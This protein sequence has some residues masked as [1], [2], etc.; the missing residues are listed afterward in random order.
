LDFFTRLYKKA[1]SFFLFTATV[2]VVVEHEQRGAA[3]V[4]AAGGLQNYKIK[5]IKKR[6]IL[7]L[8][9]GF[10]GYYKYIFDKLIIIIVLQI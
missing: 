3:A 6:I 1:I 10:L 8:V 4:G 2:Q 5:I 9:L 7:N